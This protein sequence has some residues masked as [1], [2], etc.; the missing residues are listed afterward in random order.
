M[1]EI[2]EIMNDS[3]LAEASAMLSGMGY[4][5]TSDSKHMI[6]FENEC[7]TIVLHMNYKE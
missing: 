3:E 1:R 2:I 4:L 5:K 6:T 7:G